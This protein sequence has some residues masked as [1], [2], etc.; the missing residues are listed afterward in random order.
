MA[1]MLFANSIFKNKPITIYNSGN[2]QRDFTYIDDVVEAINRLIL[3]PALANHK[4]D[5]SNPDNSSSWAPHR[6]F[7][8]GNNHPV[9]LLDF[10]HI[11][12]KEIGIKAIKIFDKERAGDIK[13]TFADNDKIYNWINF[14]PKTSLKI[15]IKNFV[16]WYKKYYKF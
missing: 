9:N 4:F 16:F 12:E 1:P 15:G 6:I 14:K 3:K 13:N 7:N 2:M 10:I 11:L 8:I 5:R